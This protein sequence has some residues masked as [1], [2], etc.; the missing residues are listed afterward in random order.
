LSIFQAFEWKAD[1]YNYAFPKFLYPF[2]EI[3]LCSSIYMTVAIAV[4]RYIG[5]CRPLRRLSGRPCAAKFYIIPVVVIAFAVNITKFLESE[6]AIIS[7][8]P[9]TNV[10]KTKVGGII[11][12]CSVKLSCVLC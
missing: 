8:D 4:E 11:T 12:S 1:W 10:T 3:A 6:T 5:L 2:S 9:I 7:V